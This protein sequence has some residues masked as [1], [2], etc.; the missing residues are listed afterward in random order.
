[1]HVVDFP[2]KNYGGKNID[3]IHVMA[4]NEY[5][6]A[7]ESVKNYIENYYDKKTG[8]L[9]DGKLSIQIVSVSKSFDM[10]FQIKAIDFHTPSSNAVGGGGC[11]IATATYGSEL[12]PQVQQLRQ[13]RDNSLL[14]TQS[15]T[16]IRGT[17][18]HSYTLF[19]PLMYLA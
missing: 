7:G 10:D 3:T 17:I 16:R 2:K 11:L 1:M 18:N 5:N 6:Q 4:S 12:A 13:L 9:L 15:G 14:Q 19:S 8:I